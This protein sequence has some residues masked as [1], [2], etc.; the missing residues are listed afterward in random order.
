MVSRECGISTRQLYYWELIGLIRPHYETF[1]MR[2]FRRYTFENLQLLKQAKSLLDAGFTLQAVRGRLKDFSGK[3]GSPMKAF[4][5]D[6]G[7]EILRR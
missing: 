5:D 6:D 7:E 1:G 4:G 3:N 2:R